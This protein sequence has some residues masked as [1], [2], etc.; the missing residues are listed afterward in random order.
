LF[1]SLVCSDF[2]FS[3][4][5]L[6]ASE[7]FLQ[8]MMALY[9]SSH[10]KN[11]PNDLQLMADAPGHHLFVLLAPVTKS[12]SK[13]ALP[14][15]LCVL[16]VCVEGSL[17]SKSLQGLFAASCSLSSLFLFNV[18]SFRRFSSAG[19]QR[20]QHVAGDL[21]PWT[22]SQQFQ[23]NDFGQLSGVRVVRIAT[24]PD[25]QRVSTYLDLLP[26]VLAAVC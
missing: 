19:L 7:A 17:S 2:Y 12:S 25:L 24:H 13:N 4:S 16:Q 6:Q 21:I 26:F 5:P 14:D 18:F 23:N 3:L 9:V 10:Y 11:S 22:V 1:I 8:R 15:I 20:G